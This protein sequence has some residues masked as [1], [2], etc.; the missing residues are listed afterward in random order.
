MVCKARGDFILSEVQMQI[1]ANILTQAIASQRAWAVDALSMLT[2][3]GSVLCHEEQA[4]EAAAKLFEQAGLETQMQPI[5]LDRIS[6]LPGFSPVDWDYSGRQNVIG[7]HR[8]STNEGRTLVF[9]G[10]IDVVPPSPTELWTTP[11]FDPC[12]FRN[13]HGEWMRGR[14]AGDMKGGSV[15]YLWA[16]MALREMGLEPASQVICQSVLEEECTGNGALAACE[17][18]H[19]GDACIIPEPFNQTILRRQVGVMWFDVEIVGKTTHV[20]GAGRGV[21]AIEKA[22]VVIQALRAFEEEVN[23]PINIPESYNE[24][25]HPINLN[26]GVIHGGD[27]ASTVA[28]FSKTRFRFGLFPGQ[29]CEELRVRIEKVIADA[30]AKDEWLKDFPPRISYT[31][32]QAEGYEFNP[33]SDFGQTLAAAHAKHSA[34][35][36]PKELTA[37]C[38]TDARFFELYYGVPCTCYGP[39]AHNIHGVDE[40][41]SIDSM[42][43][44]A[45]VMAQF[46][47]DWCGVKK[48]G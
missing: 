29:K 39:L 6:K 15:C 4:Q 34:G 14:G 42:E 7:Y 21:N 38:T 25:D 48:R 16:L 11:P 8:T 18:G 47:A 2:S 46:I 44:V 20:L 1:E 40:V 24:I 28:G 30:A 13:E 31:G 41:V 33:A 27:W 19:L 10:H 9:N 36:P 17:A 43:R 5:D 35:Q 26:T 32:F 37:T 22:W 3:H 12:V 45:A 23:E